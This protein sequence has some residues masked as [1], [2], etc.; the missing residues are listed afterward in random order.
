MSPVTNQPSASGPPPPLGQYPEN[1]VAP[2]I[3]MRPTSPASG[4]SATVSSGSR[5]GSSRTDSSGHSSGW[6]AGTSS[7]TAATS[8]PSGPTTRSSIPAN[9][10]PTDPWTGASVT[11][12][13]VTTDA[14]SDSP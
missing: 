14:D 10:R 3:L 13:V 12:E 9:A 11:S 7:E 5:S 1:S 4:A 8:R 6:S 2:R